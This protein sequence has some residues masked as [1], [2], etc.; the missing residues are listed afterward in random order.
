M[1]SVETRLHLKRVHHV[2]W[3]CHE[4]APVFFIGGCMNCVTSWRPPCEPRQLHQANRRR[5]LSHTTQPWTIKPRLV[6]PHEPH[7]ENDDAS[8]EKKQGENHETTE[9]TDSLDNNGNADTA[10][11]SAVPSHTLG[12][13]NIANPMLF[14]AFLANIMHETEDAPTSDSP[15]E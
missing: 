4:F 13:G 10:A 6:P 9:H 15:D 1:D 7:I 3:D 14:T 12:M 11:A 2:G 5:L 8:S